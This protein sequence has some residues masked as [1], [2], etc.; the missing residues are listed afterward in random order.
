M[1]V[2]VDI[3]D[4]PSSRVKLCF[5]ASSGEKWCVKAIVYE[6]EKIKKLILKKVN[7]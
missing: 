2:E 1:K 3:K 5:K 4:Y 6:Y 7:P